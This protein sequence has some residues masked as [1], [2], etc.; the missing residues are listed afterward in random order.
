[1]GGPVREAFDHHASD[2]DAWFSDNPLAIDLRKKTWEVMDR[3]FDPGHSV[4]DLGCGTGEDAVHLAGRG[5]RV[6]AVDVAPAMVDRLV[7]KARR[8]ALDDL[9]DPTVA[10]GRF[11]DLP[12]GSL[13]GIYSNFGALNCVADLEWLGELGRITLRPGG[14]MIIV[15]MGRCYP[16]EIAVNLARGRHR[17]ALRR[18]RAPA[19][20]IVGGVEF[21][22]HYHRFRVL[23]KALEGSFDLEQRRG[24]N[25][26]L[27]VPGLEHLALRFPRTFLA[28]RPIDSGLGRWWPLS[29]M[30]DHVLSVWKAR[31]S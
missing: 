10:D 12:T 13:D 22:V 18:F 14:R 30:G 2:Y 7:E 6:R 29:A 31:S 26:L 19:S 24:L 27:P 23:K 20:A 21:P 5:V 25:L 8:L 9:I 16:L 28:L 11:L 15:S 17:P 3:V 1:M 4:L